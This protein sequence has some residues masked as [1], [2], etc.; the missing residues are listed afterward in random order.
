MG[1]TRNDSAFF[2]ETAAAPQPPL[3]PDAPPVTLFSDAGIDQL[4]G[5]VEAAFKRYVDGGVFKR[6]EALT[7]VQGFQAAVVASLAM[8]E[9]QGGEDE[10]E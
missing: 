8:G 10:R 4:A 9:A 2:P 3:E 6:A 5:M 1:L 7:L